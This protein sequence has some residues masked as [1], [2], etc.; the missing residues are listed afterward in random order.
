LHIG[1]AVIGLLGD[2]MCAGQGNQLRGEV[3][4]PQGFV[5]VANK[6]HGRYLPG[7]VL[8]FPILSLNYPS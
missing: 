7:I 2:K 1:V 6:R 5:P 3:L 8:I 4:Q